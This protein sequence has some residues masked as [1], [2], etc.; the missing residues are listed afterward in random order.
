MALSILN[1]MSA[2]TAENNLSVTQAS[3]QKT[4]TQLSSGSKIT[5]G[6]DDAAGLAIANGL[7]AN[8]AALTQSVQNATNG[9]GLLQTADGA[10]SQVTTLLNRAVTLATE[11]SNGGLTTNQSAA[12]QNEYSTILTQIGNIG[13]TTNFNGKAVFQNNNSDSFTST[14]GSATS[15]LLTTTDLTAGKTMTIND[16]TRRRPATRLRHCRRPSRRRAARVERWAT[17]RRQIS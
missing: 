8:V 3:L 4:L 17:A 1:N 9:T 16:A 13:T 7:T 10:L 5:S 12:I 14:Q 11:A 2:L 6:S 15:P